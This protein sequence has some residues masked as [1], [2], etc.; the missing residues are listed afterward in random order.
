MGET[1]VLQWAED[2]AQRDIPGIK[3]SQIAK[4]HFLLFVFLKKCITL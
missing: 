2:E 3:W 4:I 1:V